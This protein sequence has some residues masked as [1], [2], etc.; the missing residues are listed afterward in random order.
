MSWK[1]NRL[2]R[3]L[4]KGT[5]LISS[6]CLLIG[7]VIA[8]VIYRVDYYDPALW[9]CVGMLSLGTLALIVFGAS[10]AISSKG[11]GKTGS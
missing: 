7:G 10:E 5:F 9:C 3:A 1:D 8:L 6:A 2:V 4:V 11:R